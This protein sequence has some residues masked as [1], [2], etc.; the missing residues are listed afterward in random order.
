[1][2]MALLLRKKKGQFFRVGEK[3]RGGARAARGG[4]RRRRRGRGAARSAAGTRSRV[5]KAIIEY[6]ILAPSSG[7]IGVYPQ[8][9]WG[10]PSKV[11]GVLV[12]YYV[13]ICNV[14]HNT[15]YSTVF[16]CSGM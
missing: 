14:F 6:V 9:R 13:C 15:L 4:W 1:M 5:I 16:G 3:E 11:L 2:K 10:F 7:K 8:I 12:V